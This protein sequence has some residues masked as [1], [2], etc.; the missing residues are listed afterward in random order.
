M[1]KH[2]SV[3]FPISN[4]RSSYSFHLIHC[5]IWGPSTIPNVFRARWFVS[6]IDDCTQGTWIF[7]LKQ[8]YDV[9]MVIPNF[10]SMVQ[11]QFAVQIKSFRTDNARDY[12]NQI[13][14]P[15]F[16]SQ[17]ILHDSL[18]VN[19]PQQNGV[20]KRKNGH[21]LNTTRVLLFQGNAPKSYWGEAV[22]TVAYLI[23]R[24]PSRVLD[25][26]SPVKVLK[27][28]YPHFRTSNAHS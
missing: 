21:L 17:G 2:T 25:N 28:F 13:L 14:S 8:K 11:N 4:K 7:L 19:P 1:A 20:A 3:S 26:K 15:Y 16:Q 18:C 27:S 12:F 6:L 22:L 23:N 24:I 9:S 5:D 10:H